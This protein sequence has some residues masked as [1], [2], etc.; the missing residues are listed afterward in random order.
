VL[1]ALGLREPLWARP[2]LDL[3]VRRPARRFALQVL[4]FDDIVGQKGLSAAASW[5]LGQYAPAWT[6]CGQSCVPRDG[7]ALIVSNHPGLFDTLILFAAIDRADLLVIAADR[8]FLRAL[9][10]VSR[11]V[12]YV[13]EDAGA[14][15]GLVRATARHLRQGGAILTF[16]GGKIEPD[17][18]LQAGAVDALSGWSESLGL[19]VRL[20]PNTPV[21]PAIV[22]GVLA[23]GAQHHPLTRIRRR[24]R[25]RE[26]LGAMLQL[27]APSRWPVAPRV[28]FGR[29]VMTT[30]LGAS[31]VGSTRW[32]LQ[33]A[34]NAPAEVRAAVL[35]EACRLIEACQAPG[36]GV[37][38]RRQFT[39]GS[40]DLAG[41]PR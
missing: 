7:P 13:A 12:L 23:K 6:A 41:P 32:H 9:P 25:D 20:A 21:I 19:F 10:N 22:S 36:G 39:A 11:C 8:P 1:G 34:Q 3:A 30:S 27:M 37:F 26:W 4:A 35:V 14:Q 5:L 2:A 38:V 29:P 33:V 28:D 24:Q 16:P 31:P 18:A 15:L 17:P 40:A